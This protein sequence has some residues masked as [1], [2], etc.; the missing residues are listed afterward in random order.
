MYHQCLGSILKSLIVTLANAGAINVDQG[1]H[2][3]T[4]RSR[5]DSTRLDSPRLDLVR[6]NVSL[7]LVSFLHVNLC[8]S[9]VHCPWLG[10]VPLVPVPL[11]DLLNAS[12]SKVN[13][14]LD[15]PVSPSHL[16][17]HRHPGIVPEDWLTCQQEMSVNCIG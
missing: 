17:S 6:V 12:L 3:Y 13:P 11:W 7:S 10:F 2:A 5:L 15:S 8:F 14:V 16:P 9:L 4:I 1:T